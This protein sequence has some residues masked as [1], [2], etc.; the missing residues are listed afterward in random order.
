MSH[1]ATEVIKHLKGYS[2]DTHCLLYLDET[3]II[4]VEGTKIST[5][6][7]QELKT[8]TTPK[9]YIVS[10]KDQ[11]TYMAPELW[12]YLLE[13]S[14]NT[15]PGTTSKSGSQSEGRKNIKKRK[16]NTTNNGKEIFLR[17]ELDAMDF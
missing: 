15:P 16:L 7:L 2:I 17:S 13:I 14:T 5:G 3:P 4:F 8:N 6:T 9:R 1:V 11:I 10:Y 12:H